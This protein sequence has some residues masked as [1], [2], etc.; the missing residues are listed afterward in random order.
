VAIPSCDVSKFITALRLVINALPLPD[1]DR[2]VLL[3]AVE[4]R[5]EIAHKAK[6]SA[7]DKARPPLNRAQLDRRA[8]YMRLY[9]AV[10]LIT[11]TPSNTGADREVAKERQRAAEGGLAEFH[12]ESR[13]R[14]AEVRKGRKRAR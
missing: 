5:A 13:R 8:A 3:A 2:A 4:Q 12:R 11:A 9:R 7:L 10:K 14:V 1:E 6:Q